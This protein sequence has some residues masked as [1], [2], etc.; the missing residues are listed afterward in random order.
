M[1][2]IFEEVIVNNPSLPLNIVNQQN[3]FLLELL[4]GHNFSKSI[5]QAF[6]Y[7]DNPFEMSTNIRLEK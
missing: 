1:N 4:R 3:T 6:G 5:D 2:D 7:L